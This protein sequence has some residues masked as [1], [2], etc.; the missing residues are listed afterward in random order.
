M[1]QAK[2]QEEEIVLDV[3]DATADGAEAQDG[4]QEPEAE[5]EGTESPKAKGKGFGKTDK[6]I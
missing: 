6:K 3:E 4:A 1:E 5:A 2:Q